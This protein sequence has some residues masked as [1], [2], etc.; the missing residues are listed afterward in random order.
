MQIRLG[1]IGGE[2]SIQMI[3]SVLK[4]YREFS[5]YSVTCNELNFVDL[6]ESNKHEADIWMCTS[7]I[8]SLIANKWGGLQ[9][10][11]YFIPYTEASLGI[12]FFQAIHQH[13]I[14]VDQTNLDYYMPQTVKGMLFNDLGIRETPRF[15]SPF[16]GVPQ[17]HQLV[18][19]HL[20]MWLKGETKLCI[21]CFDYVHDA[22]QQAGVPVLR[23]S[24]SRESVLTVINSIISATELFNAMNAQ[25]AVQVLEWEDGDGVEPDAVLKLAQHLQGDA[26]PD[27]ADGEKGIRRYRIYTTRGMLKEWTRDFKVLPAMKQFQIPVHAFISGIGIGT[28]ADEALSNA[29]K[30]LSNAR[31]Y[32]K[33]KW[34]VCF[35]DK[36]T[37]GPL[38]EP[39]Q[40]VF[41]YVSYESDE[42]YDISQQTSLSVLTLSKLSHILKKIGRSEI[43]AHE[44]ARH[45]QILPRSARRILHQLERNGFAEVVGMETPTLRG[46][47]RKMYRILYVSKQ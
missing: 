45:M 6:L 28:T 29:R 43:N 42:L 8:Y 10:P 40:A 14:Q 31:E 26:F 39:E 47:P 22:L 20:T 24:P 27:E 2:Q 41:S 16:A 12:A 13:R 38:G 37:T 21:T 18:N 17:I 23:I 4:D 32:G 3:M 33:G 7:P 19:E 44:L 15:T 30:A 46:R 9:K 36:T 34:M 1:V 11:F 25:I 5:T 35:S